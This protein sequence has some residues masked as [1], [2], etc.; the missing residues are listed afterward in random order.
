[1]ETLADDPDAAAVKPH[2]DMTFR[3]PD[4]DARSEGLA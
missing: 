4:R 3:S 1:M 2:L